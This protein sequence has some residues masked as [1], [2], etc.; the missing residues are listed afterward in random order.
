[1][2]KFCCGAIDPAVITVD[3]RIVGCAETRGV[4]ATFC[5]WTMGAT[6]RCAD[7]G[8]DLCATTTGGWFGGAADPGWPAGEAKAAPPLALLLGGTGELPKTPE[9][10]TSAESAG[11]AAAPAPAA[12][13]APPAP[14]CWSVKAASSPRDSNCKR[15]V[16][17]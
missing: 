10:S 14:C 11:A 2:M 3:V 13:L 17:S 12:E 4:A 8:A 9:R 7:G 5:D 16:G 15:R 1:M 6:G